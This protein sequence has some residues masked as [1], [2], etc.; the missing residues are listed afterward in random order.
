MFCP[1][2]IDKENEFVTKKYYPSID[3]SFL[4]CY[5]KVKINVETKDIKVVQ[6]EL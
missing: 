2:N 5:L 4:G 6:D 1:N 3:L